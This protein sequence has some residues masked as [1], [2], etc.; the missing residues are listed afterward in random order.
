MAFVTL[1][2]LAIT[3]TYR[4]ISGSIG[5]SVMHMPSNTLL[6]DANTAAA[7]MVVAMLSVSDATIIGYN[8]AYG[9]TNT[10]PAAA[11]AGSRVENKGSLSFRTAAGKITTVTVPAI[12]AAAVN[13]AG[14]LISTEASMAAMIATML[15]TPWTDSNGQDL[16]ALVSDAQVFRRT[17]KRQH[18]TDINPTT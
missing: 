6:A 9:V 3:F 11:A 10:T 1:P 16:S 5:K 17:S 2:A 18:T 14:G 4:D 8:V 15:G 13:A 7:G 12:K